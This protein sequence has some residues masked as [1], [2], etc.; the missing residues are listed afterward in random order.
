MQCAQHAAVVVQLLAALAPL[1]QLRA[2]FMDTAMSP[3]F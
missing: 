1:Y 3:D 2:W